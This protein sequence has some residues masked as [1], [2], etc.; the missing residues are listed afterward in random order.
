MIDCH[1]VVFLC[2]PGNRALC[3]RPPSSF[4][5]MSFAQRSTDRIN[6]L[7]GRQAPLSRPPV[8]ILFCIYCCFGSMIQSPLSFLCFPKLIA[9][10][11][12]L[13]D[14]VICQLLFL[15]PPIF[16]FFS[17]IHAC[18]WHSSSAAKAFGSNLF[19]LY[20]LPCSL[21]SFFFPFLNQGTFTNS[22]IANSLGL[23]FSLTT[24]YGLLVQDSLSLK[25]LHCRS[26]SISQ[27]PCTSSVSTTFLLALTSLGLF[28]GQGQWGNCPG[29][30]TKEGPTSGVFSYFYR[31]CIFNYHE[32]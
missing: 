27:A 18:P 20:L 19:L 31:M 32:L 22:L 3:R 5:T 16:P 24:E 11:I 9:G 1:F 25:H 14:V 23:A 2:L 13:F 4:P 12:D 7:R 10:A 29:P 30:T 26:T 8:G 21:F 6:L 15:H 28:L 17:L